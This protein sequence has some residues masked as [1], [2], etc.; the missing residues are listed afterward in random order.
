MSQMMNSNGGV[1]PTN[2]MQPPPGMMPP[3]FGGPPFGGPPPFGMPPPGFGPSG[4]PGNFQAAAPWGFPQPG[5]PMQSPMMPPNMIPHQQQMMPG[6]FPGLPM[7]MGMDPFSD[8][9]ASEVGVLS[10]CMIFLFINVYCYFINVDGMNFR[11][12]LL[13]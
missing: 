13:Y 1:P 6:S 5:M 9:I 7:G 2:T 8:K 11:L 10:R 3:P 12:I 4:F